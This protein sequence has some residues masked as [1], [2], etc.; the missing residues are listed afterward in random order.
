[1]SKWRKC[2]LGDVLTLQRGFDITKAAQREGLVPVVSSS[3]INSFHDEAKVAAPGVVI[4]RKGTLGTCFFLE[5]PF[6]PHDTSLWVKDFKGNDPKYCYYLL[7]SMELAKHDVGAANPTLNRNHVHLLPVVCPSLDTQ[8]RIASILGAYDDLIDL[9]RRRVALL[10]DMARGLFEEAVIRPVG[11]LPPPGGAM[12]TSTVPSGWR[13]TELGSVA[14]IIMGQSPPSA[15]LNKEGDGTP[16]HQGVSDFGDLYPDRRVF[17]ANPNPNRIADESDIL[18]SVRAPVGRINVATEKV[19]LGRGV[20]AIRSLCPDDQRYLLAHMRA[21]FPEPDLIGNGAIYKAVNRKDIER[22]PIVEPPALL[23]SQLSA[24]LNPIYDLLW[25]TEQQID[26]LAAS[27]DLLL[28][29]LIS[30]QLT[31][32]AAKRE[33]EEAA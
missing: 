33:L 28:P 3:G 1:V 24:R 31:V 25:A 13:I 19:L 18:F 26:R 4:G 8:G 23:R 15:D 16:F 9:N 5:R 12:A 32:A 7:G 17:S 11:G 20:S 10:D 30:G 14:K 21:T 22:V 29:R 6:W 2:T 27:R